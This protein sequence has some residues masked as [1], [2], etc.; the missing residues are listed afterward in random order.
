MPLGQTPLLPASKS[1]AWLAVTVAA[2]IVGGVLLLLGARFIQQRLNPNYLVD[3]TEAPQL[4]ERS[5]GCKRCMVE[6]IIVQKDGLVVFMADPTDDHNQL[7]DIA[8]IGG[9]PRDGWDLGRGDAEKAFDPGEVDWRK[10]RSEAEAW[11]KASARKRPPSTVNVV[12]CSGGEPQPICFE[13]Q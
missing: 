6:R 10:L 5:V 4:I 3:A 1:H 8:G 13:F 12:R 11:A 7:W 9:Y 2:L